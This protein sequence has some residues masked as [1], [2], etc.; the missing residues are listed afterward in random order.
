MQD[1]ASRLYDDSSG[2][3]CTSFCSKENRHQKMEVDNPYTYATATEGAGAK[4]CP[5]A[6]R[7]YEIPLSLNREKNQESGEYSTL[8]H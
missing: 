5:G 2:D 6:P 1:E 7:D 8:K 3:T 4:K